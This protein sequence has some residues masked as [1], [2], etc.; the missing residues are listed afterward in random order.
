[1][2]IQMPIMDGI[3]ACRSIRESSLNEDTPIIAVTAHALAG[4]K[5]Q[6]LKDG[7]SNYMTKPI[8]EDMLKQII[9]DHSASSPVARQ[10][11]IESH[12]HSVPPFNSQMLDWGLALQRAGNKPDLA[13]EMLNMLLSSVPETLQQLESAQDAEDLPTL[14][15]V[16]HK[17]HGA[18]C[19]T[20]VPTLKKLAEI[21]ETG[22]KQEKPLSDIEPELFE[23]VDGLTVLLTDSDLTQSS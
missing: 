11:N 16:V 3:S 8:D 18:C 7:F 1:M 20:G 19:Y 17:F 2:D 13:L 22:L 14:L 23:L 4:E 6:L 15:K 10:K 21:I 12:Q 5:E 9:C